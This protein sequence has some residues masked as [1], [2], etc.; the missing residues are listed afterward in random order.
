MTVT[1]VGKKTTLLTSENIIMI[2]I[3]TKMRFAEFKSTTISCVKNTRCKEIMNPYFISNQILYIYFF[4]I[5]P[6]LF[7]ARKEQFHVNI[8]FARH[9]SLKNIFLASVR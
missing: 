7:E 4:A 9:L 6:I 8:P 3:N 1:G 5:F 2:N